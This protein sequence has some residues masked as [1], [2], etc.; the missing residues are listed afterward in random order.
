MEA[1]A[2]GGKTV[3]M[4]KPQRE[5]WSLSN[6]SRV[7]CAR[8]M[9]GIASRVLWKPVGKVSFFPSREGSLPLFLPLTLSVSL[10]HSRSHSVCVCV[11]LVVSTFCLTRYLSHSSPLA[12]HSC[13]SLTRF[14]SLI[15]CFSLALIHYLSHT[16]SSSSLSLPHW[17]SLSLVISDSPPSHSDSLTRIVSRSLIGPRCDS[18]IRSHSFPVLLLFTQ[19]SFIVSTSPVLSLTH[20]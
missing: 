20:L 17:V 15:H 7:R 5:R 6:H 4:L 16:H 2:L 8:T 11:S 3:A 19:H 1:G 14:G 12:S 18:L 9:S 10:I 13:L